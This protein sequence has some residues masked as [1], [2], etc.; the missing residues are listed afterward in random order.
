MEEDAASWPSAF[1]AKGE[2]KA[3]I[4][5]DSGKLAGAE[6]VEKERAAWKKAVGQT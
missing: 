1:T 6:A 3:Q 4:A 5:V 2:G